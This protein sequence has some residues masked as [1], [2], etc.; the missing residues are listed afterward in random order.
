[1]PRIKIK[2]MDERVASS[3]VHMGGKVERRKLYPGEVVNLPEDFEAGKY[4][5]GQSLFELLF[6]TGK[7]EITNEPVTRPLEYASEKE[8]LMT[9]PTYRPHDDT[10][11]R[12]IAEI[13]QR[14]A[15]ELNESDSD[16]TDDDDDDDGSATSRDDIPAPKEPVARK[17]KKKAT[18]RRRATRGEKVT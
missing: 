15:Q 14:I 4:D 5:H 13:Q 2:Q 3:G 17:R 18:G 16:D 8:A 12:D 1:M 6:A 7:I 11:I 10:E 9:A